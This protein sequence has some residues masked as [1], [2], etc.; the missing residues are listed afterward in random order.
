MAYICL[1]CGSLSWVETGGRTE[2]YELTENGK[3]LTDSDFEN[4]EIYCAECD[5]ENVV[6][7]NEKKFTKEE[8]KELIE[9]W[10]KKG[11]ESLKVLLKLCIKKNYK[12]P[13]DELLEACEEHELMD[14]ELKDLILVE[15]I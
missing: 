2:V 11:K 4:V 15:E 9:A 14:D 13:Y 6:W 10:E 8:L 7:F 3:V 1:N 12:D 5:S